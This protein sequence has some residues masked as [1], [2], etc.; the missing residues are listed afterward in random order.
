MNKV[1]LVLVSGLMFSLTAQAGDSVAQM[2]FRVTDDLGNVVTNAPVR[3]STF[4]KWIPGEAFGRDE[5]AL[6]DGVTD[7]NGVVTLKMPSKT[8]DLSYGVCGR[9]DAND[10][11]LRMRVGDSS[12]YRDSGEGMLFTNNIG[13]KWQPWNPTIDLVIKRVLNPI[14]MYARYLRSG[15]FSIPAYNVSLGYDL[16][17]S[18]WLP[19]YGNGETSDFIFR[20]D[21]Q[22]GKTRADGIQLFDA[23]LSLT[24]SNE[25]DGIQEIMVPVRKGSIFRLPRFAPETGYSNKWV[26]KTFANEDSDYCEFK[27]DQN[28]IFRV[29]TKKD[30]KGRIVSA[31]YGKIVGPLFY[32]VRARGANMQMKYYLNPTPNDRNLEFDPKQN[33]LKNLPW[34]GG[35]QEP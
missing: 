6:F 25:G 11:Y 1:F 34:Q 19:P 35:V 20:L 28:F 24:F 12:Y 22:L 16:V 9:R 23:V 15:D 29:R 31:L 26:S 18:D 32:E 27:E 13:G 17:K 21:S 10:N 5:N 4:L 3:V 7:T 2:T 30:D 33:L 8:G 14:P